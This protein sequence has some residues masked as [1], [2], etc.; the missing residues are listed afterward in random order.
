[1]KPRLFIFVQFF[2]LSS[3]GQIIFEE[4]NCLD[5]S[6]NKPNAPVEVLKCHGMGGNQKWEHNRQDVSNVDKRTQANIVSSCRNERLL[7]S[8][9]GKLIHQLQ[10]NFITIMIFKILLTN[11]CSLSS[12]NSSQSCYN[13]IG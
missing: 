5:V 4:E 8:L 1:M 6:Q 11:F 7:H 12:D 13:L 2:I 3:K 9:F 10:Y